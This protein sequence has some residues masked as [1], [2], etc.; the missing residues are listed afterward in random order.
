MP[1]TEH[2]GARVRSLT[3]LAHARSYGVRVIATSAQGTLTG[4]EKTFKTSP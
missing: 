4:A 2:P 3:G 1:A